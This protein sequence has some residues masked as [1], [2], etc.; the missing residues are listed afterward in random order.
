MKCFAEAKE[1][2]LWFN[3]KEVS[4]P[5]ASVRLPFGH[6]PLFGGTTLPGEAGW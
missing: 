3:T 5:N 4:S 6:I 2:L 1:Y